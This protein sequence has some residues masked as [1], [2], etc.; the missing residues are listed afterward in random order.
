MTMMH[1]TRRPTREAMGVGP[2]PRVSGL[3]NGD[4]APAQSFRRNYFKGISRRMRI[5]GL[6]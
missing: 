6:L 3:S 5:M 1:T 2:E 4:A